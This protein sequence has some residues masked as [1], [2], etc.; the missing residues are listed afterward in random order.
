MFTW[1]GD[2]AHANRE[3]DIE[4]SAW[5]ERSSVVG[6]FVVQRGPA[7]DHHRTFV[8]PPPPWRC[9]FDWRSDRVTFRATG[10]APW[11]SPAG[12]VPPAGDVHPRL[13]LWLFGGVQ[14]TGDTPIEV[15]IGGFRFTPQLS[16]PGNR[17]G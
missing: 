17:T 9:S 11:P 8:V 15:R 1:S 2:P 16:L 10:A 5:G 14:P 6:T 3:L 13:N 4:V 7:G 12:A